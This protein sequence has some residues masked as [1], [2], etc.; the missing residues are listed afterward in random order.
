MQYRQVNKTRFHARTAASCMT[1]K[2]DSILPVL[3]LLFSKVSQEHILQKLHAYQT[4]V[5]TSI[6]LTF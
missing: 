6:R 5:I 4:I 2:F 1:V 3:M